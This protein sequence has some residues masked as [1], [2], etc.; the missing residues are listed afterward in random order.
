M[1]THL[2]V[3]THHLNLFPI[4]HYLRQLFIEIWGFYCKHPSRLYTGLRLSCHLWVT[5]KLSGRCFCV[6]AAARP[7][8]LPW[9][10]KTKCIDTAGRAKE[11]NHCHDSMVVVVAKWRQSG[12]HSDHSMNAIGRPKEAHGRE[13][14]RSGWCTMFTTVRFF[15]GRP[16]ADPCAYILHP[17]RCVCLPSASFEQPVS[18]QTPRQP[19]CDCFEHAQNFTNMASMARCERPLCHP[20]TT[21]ATVWLPLCLQRRHG[22]F[23]GR[24]RDAYRSEPICKEGISAWVS[25]K[26]WTLWK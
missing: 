1:V 3:V 4:K 20:W 13:K 25:Y 15:T 18:E 16:M 9:V 6:T 23:C 12:R 10:T 2:Q 26:L 11:Q 19:L 17:W 8:C 7:L 24:T 5:K 14:H 22:Q 21:M